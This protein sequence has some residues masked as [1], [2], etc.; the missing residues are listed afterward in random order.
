MVVSKSG[1]YWLEVQQN[2]C[3]KRDSITVNFKPVPT[4]NLGRDTTLCEGVAKTLNALYDGARYTWQ[5]LSG[6]PSYQ[7]TKPGIY[8]V[9]VDLNGCVARDSIL[10]NYKTRPQFSLGRDTSICTG[11]QL[12]LRPRL[13]NA[14]YRWQDG[15]GTANYMVREAGLYSLTA[16]NECGTSSD[17]IV[18]S[19][20][21]CKLYM[22]NA[23]TPNADGLNDVFRVKD[24][25]FIATIDLRVYNNFGELIF[26]TTDPRKGWDGN[27]KGQQ[28]PNGNYAWQISITTSD[29][30]KDYKKGTVLLIR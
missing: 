4:V 15:S 23:F 25:G 13:S 29:G 12:E 24:P 8:H 20:G 9:A 21:I 7:A 2:G 22:P 6:T 18:I 27:Y 16:T 14:S 10:I 5:D 1:T 19:K 3:S 26:R 30:E 28:Q 11:E 17:E